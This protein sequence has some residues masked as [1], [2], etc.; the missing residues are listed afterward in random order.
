MLI[1]REAYYGARRFDEFAS[2]V[3]ITDA[4]AAARLRE[5]TGA[6]LLRREPYHEPG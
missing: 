4:V 1:L 5:L 6:G 2:R 3:G